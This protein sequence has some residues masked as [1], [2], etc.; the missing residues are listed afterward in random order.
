MAG[1]LLS[2]AAAARAREGLL[3]A[4]NFG[5]PERVEDRPVFVIPAAV[6][7]DEE[8]DQGGVPF[9]P[10][11]RPSTAAP[12]RL[13]DVPCA[14]DYVD[15]APSAEN[16]G[17]MVAAK[18]EITMLDEEYQ[19]ITGFSHVEAGNDVYYYSRTEPPMGMGTLTVWQ[20]LCTTEDER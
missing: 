18:L 14:I 5:L 3:A 15:A 4:M 17:V 7:T 11:V 2:G 9:D 19:R 12:T 16:P 6:T 10:D 13:N 1:A 20:I 8:V